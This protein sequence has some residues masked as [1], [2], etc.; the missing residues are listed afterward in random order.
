MGA[1]P[2]NPPNSARSPTPFPYTGISLTAVVLLLT[3][4]IAASSARIAE[5]TSSGVSPGT[6]IM[7][8]PTLQTAVI[9]SN[10][11]ICNA[12]D[13]AAAIIPSSSD[14]G[15]NAPDSPPTCCEAI[16]PPFFTASFSNINAAVVPCAPTCSNPISSNILATESP[17]AGVGARDRSTM[18]KL[19]SNISAA[20]RATNC[21]TRVILN[22]VLLMTSPTSDRSPFGI[23]SNAVFTTPGPDTPTLMTR[24]A[25]PVPWKAPAINGLSSTAFAKATNL[26]A[27]IPSLSRVRY[28]ARFIMRPASATAAMFIPAL[29]DATFTEEHTFLVSANTSGIPFK[30]SLSGS[31]VPFCTNA[32]YPPIKSIPMASAALSIAN[33]IFSNPMEEAPTMAIGVTETRLFTI[34]IPYMSAISS[35]TETNF[36]AL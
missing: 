3:T 14:T 24:S 31:V 21:P 13:C 25:S 35:D 16:M 4:P 26:A 15:M 17:T 27:P 29:V 30:N 19:A 34:G 11:S 23:D 8:K 28:A 7:S 32:E 2:N 12:P 9:A 1:E 10:F 5:R 22:A 36:P 33:A 18:P 20:L 6:A